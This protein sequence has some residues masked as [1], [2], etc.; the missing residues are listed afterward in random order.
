MWNRW[1]SCKTKMRYNGWSHDNFRNCQCHNS[2]V[3]FYG[4]RRKHKCETGFLFPLFHQ[5]EFDQGVGISSYTD[6]LFSLI[7]E[8]NWDLVILCNGFC[9]PSHTSNLATCWIVGIL[10]SNVVPAPQ[11][12]RTLLIL[13]LSFLLWPPPVPSALGSRFSV[14]HSIQRAGGQCNFVL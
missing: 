12:S 2:A 1:R 9:N 5:W 13:D 3:L 11:W 4:F 8:N 7:L 14:Q 10:H 6:L